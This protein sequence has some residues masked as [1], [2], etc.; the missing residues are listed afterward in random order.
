[1][2]FYV[3]ALMAT[4]PT[5]F[6]TDTQ[7]RIYQ[8]LQQLHIDF[9]RADTDDGTTM[10]DCAYISEGLQCPVVKTILVCNRQQT[11]F[12]L[13]VTTAEKPFV[14][15][16]FCSALSISRVSF[17]P[18][19]MLWQ[20]LGTRIGATTLLSLINDPQHEI[21]TVIDNEVAAREWFACTD[22]TTTCFMKIRMADVMGKFL[23]YTGHQPRFIEV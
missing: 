1:M 16:D 10:E 2:N 15:K 6:Q 23:P 3:S 18:S 21:V 19:D 7:R 13:F 22:G 20:K 17:A 14:T 9:Q 12:Y 8:M 5:E 11:Q 4:P